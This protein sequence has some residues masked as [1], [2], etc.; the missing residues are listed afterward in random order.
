MTATSVT[1]LRHAISVLKK[2]PDKSKFFRS[3]EHSPALHRQE[4]M[5]E[6]TA[7]CWLMIIRQ[8]EQLH[9]L[10]GW[11]QDRAIGPDGCQVTAGHRDWLPRLPGHSRASRFVAWVARSQLGCTITCR[12]CQMNTQSDSEATEEAYVCLFVNPQVADRLQS[13]CVGN[14]E[15][16]QQCGKA[17]REPKTAKHTEFK[18]ASS[19]QRV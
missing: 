16:T 2:L 9:G 11:Q 12:G 15:N 5:S 13:P 7:G 18:H 6:L 10:P 8:R 1:D 3:N 14:G 17:K 19:L 4:E